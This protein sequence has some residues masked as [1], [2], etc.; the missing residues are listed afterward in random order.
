M[1][2]FN[3]SG[4][5]LVTPMKENGDIDYDA[6]SRLIE[7]VIIQGIDFLV[8]VGTTGESPTLSHEEQRAVMAF[9]VQCAAG[10]IP[11]MAGTG[12]NNTREAVA[13]TQAAL[14][15]D[16]DAALVVSPYYNKPEPC[17]MR[18]YY[19][20]VA[21]IGLPVCL[22][23]IPGRTGRGVP[24]WLVCELANEG[25]IQGLKWAD[26]NFDNL[27]YIHQNTSEVFKI[28]SGDDANTL[29]AMRLGAH[30]VISVIANIYP[31]ETAEFVAKC[32]DLD[33]LGEGGEAQMAHNALVDIM[34]VLFIE[35]NPIPIKTALEILYGREY[36]GANFRSPMASMMPEAKVQLQEVLLTR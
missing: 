22:Y 23:D 12:S 33:L 10:R 29:A 9:T 3:G 34:D 18:D 7:F 16:A 20:N 4:V 15:A 6:L 1:K 21:E 17:G 31:H 2:N 36:G 5:A 13:L 24:P 8:P 26:G 28:F 11:V 27:G 30:G 19:E 25:I 14:E 32:G 35:S